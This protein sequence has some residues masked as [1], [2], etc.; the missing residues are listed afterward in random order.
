MG[1]AISL[2]QRGASAMERIDEVLSVEPSI[3]DHG[4]SCRRRIAARRDRIPRSVVQVRRRCA[5]QGARRHRPEGPGRKLARCRGLGGVGQVDPGFGD[6]AA[7]RGGRRHGLP[8]RGRHQSH[9]PLGAALGDRHG[10]PGLVPVLDVLA[11]EH[12]LRTASGRLGRGDP[13]GG[14]ARTAGAGR[15]GSARSPTTRSSG[16]AA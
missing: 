9:P 5:G 15:R 10:A 6:S 11:G 16:S 2:V 4:E 7:L 8:G 12:R 3:A 14:R 1:F 13:C